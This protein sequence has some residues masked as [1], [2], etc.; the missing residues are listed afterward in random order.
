MRFASR[1]FG[2]T[3][4][5][6]LDYFEHRVGLNLI[7]RAAGVKHRLKQEFFEDQVDKSILSHDLLRQLSIN[8]VNDFPSHANKTNHHELTLSRLLL[9]RNL[10]KLLLSRLIAQLIISLNLLDDLIEQKLRVEEL[11]I[12]LFAV[13][14]FVVHIDQ[15]VKQ[16]KELATGVLANQVEFA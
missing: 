14:F 3:R 12:F 9:L 7:L 6:F 11:L 16:I 13:G 1:V 10:V 5:L 4:S 8:L 15:R 2:L